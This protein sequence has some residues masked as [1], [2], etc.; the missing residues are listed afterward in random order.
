MRWAGAG[1]M[2]QR[3][4][5]GGV[6]GDGSGVRSAAAGIRRIEDAIIVARAGPGR[7]RWQQTGSRAGVM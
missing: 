4:V 3:Q 5:V 7:A 1:Q 2:A 6:L